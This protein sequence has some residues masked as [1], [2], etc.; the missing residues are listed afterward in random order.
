MADADA[1]FARRLRKGAGAD[2]AASGATRVSG[3]LNFKEKYAP[4][5]PRVE[6]VHAS[7]G[8]VVTRAVSGSPRRRGSLGKSSARCHPHAGPPPRR[9]GLAKLPA[10]RG[11]RTAGTRR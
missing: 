5:F 6:T 10:L 2:L 8:L 3:S 11:K 9:P 7:P 1:D 4:A